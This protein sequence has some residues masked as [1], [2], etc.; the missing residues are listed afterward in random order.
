MGGSMFAQAAQSF[1]PVFGS[2]AERSRELRGEEREMRAAR[3]AAAEGDLSREQDLRAEIDR[4]L[5][6]GGLSPEEGL[7]LV[8]LQDIFPTEESVDA[9]LAQLPEITPAYGPGA[10]IFNA[11]NRAGAVFGYQPAPATNAAVAQTNFINNRLLGVLARSLQ[12]SRP[13]NFVL[14]LSRDL[15]AKPAVFTN[16][17]ES[18]LNN[19]RLIRNSIEEDMDAAVKAHNDAIQYEQP[20]RALDRRGDLNAL[21]RALIEVSAVIRSLEGETGAGSGGGGIDPNAL[22]Q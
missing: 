3:L 16:T 12:E 9:V 15:L 13:S 19:F 18:A 8:S 6:L 21:R 10:P 2:M 20:R 7:P 14:E 4:Q 22:S 17:P 1:A 5:M 11:F